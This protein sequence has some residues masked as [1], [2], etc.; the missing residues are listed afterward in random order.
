MS[1][2]Y[3]KR[4]ITTINPPAPDQIGVGEVVINATTGI[5]YS[6]LTNGIVVKYLPVYASAS[7]VPVI[8]FSDYS[9]F[10]CTGDTLTA[11]VSNLTV[12]ESYTYEF[13]DL[14][15]NGVEFTGDQTGSLLPTSDASRSVSIILNMDGPESVTLVKFTVRLNNVIV[16]ENIASICCRACS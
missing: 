6:K 1:A 15:N 14:N 16:A 9:T 13:V 4:D 3:M 8:T 11:T 5:M 12:G 7:T 2:G 10:C